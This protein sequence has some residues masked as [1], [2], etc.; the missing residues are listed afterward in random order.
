MISEENRS[1]KF[2]Y[3]FLNSNHLLNLNK[4]VIHFKNLKKIHIQLYG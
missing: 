1:W 4:F 3:N 2:R